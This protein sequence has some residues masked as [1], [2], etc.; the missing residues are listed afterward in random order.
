[1]GAF[2]AFGVRIN[3]VYKAP[4]TTRELLGP[5]NFRLSVAGEQLASIPP[6]SSQRYLSTPKS[7]FSSKSAFTLVSALLTLKKQ[8]YITLYIY[9]YICKNA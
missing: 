6:L 1:M 3:K 9:I 7:L 4:S 8:L 5:F 2:N